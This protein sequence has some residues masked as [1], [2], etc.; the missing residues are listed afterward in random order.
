MIMI[1]RGIYMKIPYVFKK[2]TKCGRWLVASTVNFS[3]GKGCK[4]GLRSDCKTCQK[5]YQ[6]E[7]REQNKGKIAVQKKERYEQ[8]KDKILAKQKECYEQNKEK[9]LAR[10]KKWREQNKDKVKEY[11][12]EYAKLHKDEIKEYKKEW[13]K[14]NIDKIKENDK[15][16][17]EQN[18]VP[19][20]TSA[21]LTKTMA[22]RD[23]KTTETYEI[24]RMASDV[25]D[26]Y[27]NIVK[28]IDGIEP[29]IVTHA[30]M[31]RV[32]KIME[33][34]FESDRTGAVVSVIDDEP[35]HV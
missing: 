20:V 31:M 6:K 22:P 11:R 34:A 14:Q 18:V 3:K 12:K 33:A 21:G 8:N 4:Y 16:W 27:R 23:E 13:R 32:M 7:Y 26:F 28:A 17:Y 24:E 15:K 25:H 19:V 30:Q 2:C 5:A 35:V 10:N 1:F 29:Q 9:I